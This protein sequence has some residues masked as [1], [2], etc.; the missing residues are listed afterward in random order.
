[1]PGLS[2]RHL[3]RAFESRFLCSPLPSSSDEPSELRL[4]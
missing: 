4:G 1:L 2:K 3:A